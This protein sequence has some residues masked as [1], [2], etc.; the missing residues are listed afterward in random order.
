[1]KICPYC[2]KEV[3]DDSVKCKFCGGWFANDATVEQRKIDREKHVDKLMQSEKDESL[4][5]I[6]EGTEY[7]SVPTGKLILLCVLSFGLY[8]LYWFYQ[9]WKAVKIQEEKK[10]SPFWRAVFSVFYCYSLFKRI[11]IS[12]GANGFKTK[13][14]PTTLTVGYIFFV[15]LNRLPDPLWCLSFLTFVP[16]IL[17]CNAIRFNNAKI[18]TEIKESSNLSGMEIF[19][20]I[21]G[22]LI[23]GVTAL[24]MLY[25]VQ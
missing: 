5:E 23:W 6:D 3:A 9:N 16:I 20:L 17:A 24:S 7:F 15:M 19:L 21:F 2:Q 4:K 13:A 8:E 1:V 22:L 14:T 25:P 10:L 12:A 11:L 18:N